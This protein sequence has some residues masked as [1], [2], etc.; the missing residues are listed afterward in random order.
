M[1]NKLLQLIVA[2]GVLVLAACNS[3]NNST[4]QNSSS[5]K[6]SLATLESGV[7]V[8]GWPNYI[9][10]GGVTNTAPGVDGLGGFSNRPVDAIFKYSG[11]DGAGDINQIV[12]PIFTIN[13]VNLANSISV[14]N[15]HRTQPVMVNYMANMSITASLADFSQS[16]ITAHL[17]NLMMDAAV[18]E[19]NRSESN[20]YPGSLVLAPD[21][22]GMMQQNSVMPVPSGLNSALKKA[23]CFVSSKFQ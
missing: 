11:Y 22:L 5:A 12:F 7:V 23:A 6:T 1:N 14:A 17:I 8:N 4:N 2:A 16:A 21:L 13:T 3:G 18:M 9:A 19:A 20:P 15:Q 10:M